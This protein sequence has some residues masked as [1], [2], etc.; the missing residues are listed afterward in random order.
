MLHPSG[1]KESFLTA[2]YN[3]LTEAVLAVDLDTRHILYWNKGAQAMFGYT[4]EEVLGKT[5]RFLYPSEESYHRIYELGE[6]LLRK[7]GYWRTEWEYC[8]RSGSTFPAGVG[9]TTFR[10]DGRTYL[11]DVIRDI[12][13]RKHIEQSLL[14]SERLAAVGITAS[15]LAHEISNPLNGMYM[16]VQ[17]LEERLAA[18]KD[19]SEAWFAS[20][21]QDLKNEI[22]RLRSL[23]QEFR[24]LSRPQ[25]LKLA[26]TDVRAMVVELLA[27]E[28]PQYAR[29]GIRTK[30]TIPSKIPQ[31]MADHEKLKQA[32]L[33]LFINAVEAMP[34]GGLL[35]VQGHVRGK[36]LFLEITDTGSGVPAGLNVFELFTTSKPADTGLG[37]PIVRQILNGHKGTVTYSSEPG[38]GTTF[39]I[40]LPLNR[41]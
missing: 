20:R 33:N 1:L 4:A 24:S 3:G 35:T 9:V 17:L 30:V 7:Q 22:R 38:K 28:T 18:Q 26:P 2:L 12:T 10:Q 21:V 5:T 34:Q 31:V 29:Q 16:T 36:E 32:L 13:D 25:Q 41:A 14:E 40:K 11:V 23:L 15:K 8:R 6:P 19:G 39:R 37:L 27:V